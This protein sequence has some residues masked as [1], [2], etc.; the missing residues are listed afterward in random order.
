MAY[1]ANE[2][3][4]TSNLRMPGQSH[5]DAPLSPKEARDWRIVWAVLTVIVIGLMVWAVFLRHPDPPPQLDACQSRGGTWVA[6]SNG[7]SLCV[8]PPTVHAISVI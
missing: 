7:D 5:R 3:E 8:Q 1:P 4:H 2:H 6:R